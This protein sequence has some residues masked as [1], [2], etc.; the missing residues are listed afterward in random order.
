[1][2]VIVVSSNGVCHFE[3]MLRVHEE[4]SKVR[5]PGNFTWSDVCTK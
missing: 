5:S 2:I 3:Q 4:V 1:M